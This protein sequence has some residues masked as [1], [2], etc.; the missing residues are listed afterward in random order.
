[1]SI[2]LLVLGVLL[3]C[4]AVHPFVTYPLS[5]TLFAHIR[6]RSQAG[7]SAH[8][9]VP[10][11]VALCVC[12]YNEERVVR[13]KVE[14]MLAMCAAAPGLEL[15][16]YVDAAT[17]RTADI[18]GEYADKLRLVVSP[19]RLG[20]T[21]G[22]NTLVGMTQAD[23]VVFSDANVM[24][25]SDAI[26]QLL[27]T[28]AAPDVGCVCG[29]LV[30]GRGTDSP[31]AATGSLYWRLEEKIKELESASGSVMGAD[32]SI[33]AIRRALHVC[34]P[35]DL[36]DDMYVSLSVLGQG[37]RIV[38]ADDALAFEET[39]SL[40]HEEF[41]RKIRIACQAFN[42]HRALHSQIAKLSLFDQYKYVSHK[43]LRWLTAY[44]L[45]GSFACIMAG[46]LVDDAWQP[47]AALVS[48]TVLSS[49]LIWRTDRGRFGQ[50]RAILAAFIA[51]AIGVWFSVRGERFQTWNSPQS[52]RDMVPGT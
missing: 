36:I 49:V 34:P 22:M 9:F 8:G 39:V 10:Q 42:V 52:A 40:P 38:R 45:A 30:Y 43:L 47:A 11:R 51:T 19:R 32:G 6:R 13:R 26:P 24:F 18:L 50:I 37:A 29:H 16:A 28:F 23:I 20:K 44:L 35:S 48:F 21:E 33:F 4:A 31:T 7:T 27:S 3:A 12:F 15:L 17:D 2:A 46:L 1:V 14:N 25:A 41:R 5:L